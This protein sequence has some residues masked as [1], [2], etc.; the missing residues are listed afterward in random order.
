MPALPAIGKLTPLRQL[1]L[2]KFHA[3]DAQRGLLFLTGLTRLTRLAGFDKA[4]EAAMRT[5]WATINACTSLLKLI[6]A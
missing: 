6:N 1:C 2:G 5:F 4:G 3:E